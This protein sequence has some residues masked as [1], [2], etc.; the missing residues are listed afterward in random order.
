MLFRRLHLV[1]LSGVY[2]ERYLPVPRPL[3]RNAAIE[4]ARA[5]EHGRGFAVVADEVRS[6][7]QRTQS[8]AE[9]QASVAENINRNLVDIRDDSEQTANSTEQVSSAIAELARLAES[10]NGQLAKFRV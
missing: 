4:A 10:L 2:R 7:A 6:L 9:E 5:G 3:Q 8:S 1:S